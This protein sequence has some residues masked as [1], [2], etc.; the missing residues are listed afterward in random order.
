MNDS[1]KAKMKQIGCP[2][3][4]ARSA[5]DYN[6]RKLDGYGV[7]DILYTLIILSMVV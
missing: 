2:I 6:L 1:C 5:V 3:I 7:W 4:L